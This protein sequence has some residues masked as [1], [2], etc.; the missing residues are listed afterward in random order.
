MV[1]ISLSHSKDRQMMRKWPA[2][3]GGVLASSFAGYVPLAILWL[4]LS[5][6]WADVIVIS[7]TEFNANRLLNIKTTA[8]TVF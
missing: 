8:G 1:L 7:R 3:G 5:H 6:F 2:P 4:N